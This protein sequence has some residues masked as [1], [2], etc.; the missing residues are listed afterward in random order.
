MQQTEYTKVPGGSAGTSETDLTQEQALKWLRKNR[1]FLNLKKIAARL[2]CSP[3][4][5]TVAVAGGKNGRGYPVPF[6]ER[7]LPAMAEIIKQFSQ[8]PE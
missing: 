6:P 4:I 3:S 8:M 5:I 2:D 7:C 1:E